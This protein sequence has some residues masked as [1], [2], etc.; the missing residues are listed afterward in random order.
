MKKIITALFFVALCYFGKTPQSFALTT[1]ADRIS[2]AIP[3]QQAMHAISFTTTQA[4]PTNGKVVMSFP[5]L[6]SNDVNNSASASA[7]TFQ[8]NNLQVSQIKVAEENADFTSTTTFSLSNSNG[9]GSSPTITMTN[10]GPTIPANTIIA[11]YLGCTQ[12][13]GVSCTNAVPTIINPAKANPT[14]VSDIWKL[15]IVTFDNTGNRLESASIQIV[16]TDAVHIQATILPFLSFIIAGLPDGTAINSANYCGTLHEPLQTNAGL[17]ASSTSVDLGTLISQQP[18]Y[19]GQTLTLFSNGLHGYAII[20]TGSGNMKGVASGYIIPNAQGN[21]TAANTPAP[22]PITSTQEAFG[23]HACDAKGKVNNQFWGT[24]PTKFANPSQFYYTIGSSDFTPS[25]NGDTM[26]VIYGMNV[27]D[28]TPGGLYQ[29]A[30]TYIAT[31]L[32]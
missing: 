1:S 27:I 25:P 18:H 26:V 17:H 15:L 5:P 10:I 14:G 24:T 16:T 8:L 19:A 6:G 13:N 11:I 31:P 22:L 2:N 7:T 9:A 3:T 28:K 29:T 21:P 30:L 12:I 20:A 4:I 23:I 32:F